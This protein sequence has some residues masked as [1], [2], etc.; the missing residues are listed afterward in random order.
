MKLKIVTM[1]A[2]KHKLL[3]NGNKIH[4]PSCLADAYYLACS[5]LASELWAC[6][7][8]WSWCQH[9]WYAWLCSRSLQS[10]TTQASTNTSSNASP[11][12]CPISLHQE[13]LLLT[14]CLKSQTWCQSICL[15]SMFLPIFLYILMVHSLPLVLTVIAC[16]W[17]WILRWSTTRI[18]SNA[19]MN[20]GTKFR[21]LMFLT[22]S[23]LYQNHHGSTSWIIGGFI[24][25]NI[26]AASFMLNHK[27]L[28][29]WS[30]ALKTIPY[31]T[32]IQ[33][34]ASY[35]Y[36]Y[37]YLSSSFML[38]IIEMPLL[39]RIL[40]NGLEFPLVEL[41]NVLIKLLLPFFHVTMKPSISLMPLKRRAQSHMLIK[42]CV[43]NGMVVFC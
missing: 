25:L 41:R 36:I 28:T 20:Y 34:T 9:Q 37:S 2:L 1:N 39:L 42:L 3:E 8:A 7:V 15:I 6:D 33:T 19:I 13:Y 17:Y 40:L 4:F 14:W 43:W 30:T 16:A 38:G 10:T 35:Q 22:Q 23:L 21:Q 24:T 26:F 11:L 5:N 27:H 18:G 29:I 32:T 12:Y 31:S